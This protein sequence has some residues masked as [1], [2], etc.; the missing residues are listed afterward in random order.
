MAYKAEMHVQG[1]WCSNAIVLETREE[2]QA[3]AEDL[4]SRWMAPDDR[5]VIESDEAVNYRFDGRLI[6][7]KE[8][9]S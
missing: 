3:Y 9:A 5:R 4:F 6:P 2:A 8:S 7:V 1:G